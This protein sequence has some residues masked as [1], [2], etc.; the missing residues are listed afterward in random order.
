MKKKTIE[1]KKTMK[2][3]K[4]KKKLHFIQ[5]HT[6]DLE[7]YIIVMERWSDGPCQALL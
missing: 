3:K 6:Q 1:K 5:L 2:K 4:K 7:T